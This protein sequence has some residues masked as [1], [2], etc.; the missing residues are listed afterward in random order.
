VDQQNDAAIF[1]LLKHTVESHGCRIIDIDLATYRID[2][3]GP[4]DKVAACAEAIERLMNKEV[5]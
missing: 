5:V 4:D 2:I 3:D 1:T